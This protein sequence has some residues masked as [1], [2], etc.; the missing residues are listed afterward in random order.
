[1]QRSALPD[2][3]TFLAV[4]EHL[5]FRAAA[6]QL[7]LTSP[8]VSHAIRQLEERLG[9][10]LLNRTTRS[11]SLTQAGLHLRDRLRPAFSQISG[12]LTELYEER[13]RPSGQLRI[14]ASAMA[15]TVAVA[16]MWQR[17]VST[18][19][20]VQLELRVELSPVDI[21][22]SGFDAGIGPKGWVPADMIAVRVTG[23]LSLVVVGAPSY[24]ATRLPPRTPD[25]LV[26][27]RCIQYR[28]GENDATLK[29]S[30]ERNGK[31]RRIAPEGGLTV[32]EADLAIHAAVD[33]LGLAYTA[34]ALVAPFLR[35][36]Q[37]VQV[38]EGWSPSVEGLFLF[39]H[40]HRQVPIAL[41]AFIDMM[42][43]PK[44]ASARRSI[45]NPF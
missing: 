16:P 13:Q 23:P 26:A 27:H 22:A 28:F 3:N 21:V 6:T 12:A 10:R 33:G 37:L 20:E 17:F 24:F 42:R 15:L 43:P 36:G 14:R 1:M 25:D 29:W 30:F 31:T 19:P 18:Y 35:T 2:L 40:G 34:E 38:L 45:K 4:A 32:N 11:V 39:Y 9:V 41:R 8:A 5:S 7:G 44:S